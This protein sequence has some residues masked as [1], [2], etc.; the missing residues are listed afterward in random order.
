MHGVA[1]LEK[2]AE[3]DRVIIFEIFSLI[4]LLLQ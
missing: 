4:L 1:V 2:S 3:R